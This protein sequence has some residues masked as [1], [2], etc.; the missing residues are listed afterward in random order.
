MLDIFNKY[1]H[2]KDVYIAGKRN[3]DGKRFGTAGKVCILTDHLDLIKYTIRIPI[4]NEVFTVCITKIEEEI[5]YLFNGYVL[6][7]SINYEED[8]SD[9]EDDQRSDGQANAD[10]KKENDYDSDDIY[11]SLATI[12]KNQVVDG[13][14]SNPGVLVND[15]NL[16]LSHTIPICKKSVTHASPMALLNRESIYAVFGARLVQSENARAT[17]LRDQLVTID[18]K[19]ESGPLNTTEIDN[20]TNTVKELHDL[21]HR[22]IKDIRQKAK[23]RWALEGDENSS[24]FHVWECGGD[25]APS[26]N[27]FTFKFIKSHWDILG[28][29]IFRYMK[30]FETSS[31]IP[32]WCNSSFI[33]LIPKV[34][35]P[36]VIHDY[37]PISLIG[38]QYKIIAK[39]LANRLALV[40]SSVVGESQ[41]VFIKGRQ[42]INGPLMVDEIIS[43]A[44]MYNKKLFMLKV[45]FEKAF[46]S[47]SWSFLDSTMMQMGF[48]LKW[49]QWMRACLNLGYTSVLIN[50]SSTPEFKIERGL[51]QGGPLSPL[52]FILTIE[53][54]NVV[55]TE[56][57]SKNLFKG[58]K[59][60]KD[61]VEVSHFQFADDALIIGEWCH[62]VELHSFATKISCLPSTFPCTYLG[63]PIGA[64]MSR[65]LNWNPLLERF[66]KRSTKWKS[67]TLSFGG[68]LTL[69]KSVL[70]S[71]GVYFF[72]TFKAPK[73]IINKLECIRRKFFWGGSLD[74]SK[75]AW[76]AWDK[77]ISPLNK[78]GLSVGSLWVSNLGLL[79][80][81]WWRF[82]NE[83][84]SLWCKVI[85]S[86]HGPHGGL[87][88]ASSIRCKS[89]PWYHIAKLKDDFQDYGIDIPSLFK[90]KR[91]ATV[92]LL[93]FVLKTNGNLLR[94]PQEDSS[95]ITKITT[96]VNL[97]HKGIDLHSVVSLYVT[98]V[99]EEMARVHLFLSCR[100]N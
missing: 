45:D 24:F 33:T 71:L 57:K 8:S 25:K 82:L 26:V 69:T 67:K 79:A 77:V 91:L 27:G 19:A 22:K 7:S 66:T 28:H 72:S 85:R 54:L 99:V 13:S 70:G 55:L 100:S 83:R 42:I 60:G 89:G 74:S 87:L 36:L 73:G 92:N 47:F 11:L 52:L 61:K 40:I 48:S 95:S 51:R 90:K 37:R 18:T 56:A 44:K 3:K 75:I 41:T 96:R 4:E 68:R 65:C 88:N 1:G 86:I 94:A 97:V 31:L 50:G 12:L 59:V 58:V 98:A 6:S 35:D 23:S 78:G 29:D 9:E 32:R 43:W 14:T 46:D 39:V 64:K 93:A 2:A 81:W 53:A 38:C 76:I 63:L 16:S 15:K 21:E 62:N 80:K 10:L 5:D 30:E 17:V 34:E 49:R 20:R 84:D